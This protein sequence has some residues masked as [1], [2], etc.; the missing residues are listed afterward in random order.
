MILLPV[1]LC[2]RVNAGVGLL[3]A[4]ARAALADPFKSKS[5]AVEPTVQTYSKQT[6]GRVGASPRRPPLLAVKIPKEG[7]AA[8]A[9]PQSPLIDLFGGFA[10]SDARAGRRGRVHRGLCW[11][12]SCFVPHRVPAL[13]PRIGFVPAL[14]PLFGG[15]AR[16]DASY[17]YAEQSSGA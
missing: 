11:L 3:P 12:C 14:L 10:R 5:Q 4:W 13:F 6:P 9:A 16:S 1:S 8:S 15:F 7:L 2:I 17:A